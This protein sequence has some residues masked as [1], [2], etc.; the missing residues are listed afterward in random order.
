MYKYSFIIV[1]LIA[2]LRDT[3]AQ[4]SST[5]IGPRAHGMGYASV[6]L[7]DEWS[8]FN[9]VAGLGKIKKFTGSCTYDVNA[10]FKPFS[11]TAATINIPGKIGYAFGVYRFGDGQYQEQLISAGIGSTL[12]ITS[13]GLKVNYTRYSVAGLGDKSV[14]TI[15]FGGNTQLTPRLSI[16]A[17]ISNLNQ[18]YLSKS[19]KER[20]PTIMTAG[21]LFKATDAFIMAL[22]LEKDIDYPPIIKAGIEYTV[23][24]KFFFRTGFNIQPEAGFLGFGYKLRKFHADYSMQY[25]IALG[26]HHQ[27][28]ISYQF[29]S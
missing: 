17:C 2:L 12:G 19:D 8:L 25:S 18:V 1:M 16:G 29:K 28:G 3:C 11:K 22:E 7:A 6:C 10:I 20:V 21:F 24:R 9:N 15:G 14:I 26:M 13:L 23:L 5:L 27:A 4:S